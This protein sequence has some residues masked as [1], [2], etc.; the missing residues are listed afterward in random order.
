[1]ECLKA[2]SRTGLALLAFQDGA[3]G[4]Q[5]HVAIDDQQGAGKIR[6]HIPGA[7][8][9]MTGAELFLLD[10]ALRALRLGIGANLFPRRRG[11]DHDLVHTSAFEG[12]D[13]MA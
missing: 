12:G 5:G 6:Q 3:A 9:G 4:D 7:G 1:L 11:H 13:D 2:Q 8:C 10:G